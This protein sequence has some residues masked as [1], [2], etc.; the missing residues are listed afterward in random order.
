MNHRMVGVSRDLKYHL[1]C[2]SGVERLVSHD[3]L[4]FHV[5]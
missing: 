1:V 2:C 5:P 4:E 3:F